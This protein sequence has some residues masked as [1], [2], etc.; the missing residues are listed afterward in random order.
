[1]PPAHPPSAPALAWTDASP[2][3]NTSFLE[4]LIGYNARRAAL[5]VIGVFLERMAPFDLRVVD[6]SVLT[7]IAHNP[8]ITS[9]QLSAALAILP[10]NLV[11]LVRQLEA[12]GLIE[13][14]P[15]PHDR[16]AQ[17]LY[18]TEAGRSLQ[19]EAQAVVASLETEAITHL[20]EDERQTLIRLLRKVYQPQA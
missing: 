7:L 9:R 16:R 8:G 17:G 11:G 4:G 12:R 15:H 10:P 19:S 3:V 14:H 18:V 13:K 2:A 6:F 5:A 20:S 1:M